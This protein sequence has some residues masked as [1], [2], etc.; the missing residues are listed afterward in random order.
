MVMTINE[1]RYSFYY[2]ERYGGRVDSWYF[3]KY[4]GF[5]TQ[6]FIIDG[7]HMVRGEATMYLIEKKDKSWV[8]ALEYLSDIEGSKNI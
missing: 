5:T 7:K 3:G 6:F 2:C 1:S 4:M 8:E